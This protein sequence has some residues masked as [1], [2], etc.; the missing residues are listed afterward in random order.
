MP[1]VIMDADEICMVCG[2]LI[3]KVSLRYPESFRNKRRIAW[4]SYCSECKTRVDE[5]MSVLGLTQ[6]LF[7]DYAMSKHL[8]NKGIPERKG[9]IAFVE[10]VDYLLN[11]APKLVKQTVEESR[12]YLR[13]LGALQQGAKRILTAYSGQLHGFSEVEILINDKHPLKMEDRWRSRAKRRNERSSGQGEVISLDVLDLF[14]PLLFKLMSTS[15]G[16]TFDLG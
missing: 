15:N 13:E 11:N 12:S 6:G 1:L 8:I 10:S 5:G 2:K 7:K 4:N 14:M 9:L 3:R 16:A